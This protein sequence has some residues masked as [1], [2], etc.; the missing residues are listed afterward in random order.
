MPTWSSLTVPV[1]AVGAV[2]LGSRWVT[3]SGTGPVKVMVGGVPV[4]LVTE[5]VC[6][7][8]AVLPA[9]SLAVATMV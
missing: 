6:V 8:V 1:T 7:L 5:R 9:A 3:G 4:G 2:M